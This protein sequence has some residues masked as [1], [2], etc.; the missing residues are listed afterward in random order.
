[1]IP[2]ERRRAAF[3]AMTDL[4][5]STATLERPR[6]LRIASR[7]VERVV[8][9]FN[10][11]TDEDVSKLLSAV[12]GIR[13]WPEDEIA[14]QVRLWGMTAEEKQAA[15]DPWAGMGAA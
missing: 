4:G 14:E 8:A 11:L 1:V 2:A 15:E 5:V 7:I 9:S 6:R 12:A 3:Q 10:D 13:G